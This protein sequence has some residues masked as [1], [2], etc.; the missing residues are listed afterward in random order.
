MGATVQVSDMTSFVYADGELIPVEDAR[1]V[2]NQKIKERR[3]FSKRKLTA[4][5]KWM[6]LPDLIRE[7]EFPMFLTLTDYIL[8][9]VGEYIKIKAEETTT[10]QS[11]T[12]KKFIYEDLVKDLKDSVVLDRLISGKPWFKTPPPKSYYKHWYELV[13]DGEAVCI[14]VQLTMTTTTW[15]DGKSI[16]IHR[17]ARIDGEEWNLIKEDD[18]NRVYVVQWKET[19]YIYTLSRMTGEDFERMLHPRQRKLV[20]KDGY[21]WKLTRLEKDE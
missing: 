7:R 9:K 20:T 21:A 18:E 12:S 19:E 3:A 2:E 6:N 10:Y 11:T 1:A 5:E 8:N 16:P 13:D 17:I 14:D 4:D 15:Q